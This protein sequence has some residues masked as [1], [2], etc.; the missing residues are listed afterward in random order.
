M[1]RERTVSNMD[2]QYVVWTRGDSG[3]MP[4]E[5]QDLQSASAAAEDLADNGYDVRVHAV[6]TLTAERWIEEDE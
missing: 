1:T 4:G 6:P 5:R 3:W 2:K